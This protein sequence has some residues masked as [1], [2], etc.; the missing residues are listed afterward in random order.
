MAAIADTYLGERNSMGQVSGYRLVQ[1]IL[2]GLTLYLTGCAGVKVASVSTSDYMAARRGDI[3]TTGT[4]SPATG[5]VLQM[6]GIDESLC[7][8]ENARCRDSLVA[9]EALHSEQRLAALSELWLQ[10]AIDQ[11]KNKNTQLA[12]RIAAYIES[13]R[14]AYAYL[15]FTPRKPSQRALEDRQAQVR[16]YYN[17]ATQQAVTL[18]F[19][20]QDQA[21]IDIQEANGVFVIRLANWEIQG[22][23]AEVR[24]ASGEQVPNEVIP[25]AALTFKGIR[26]QYRRDGLGA[27]LVAVTAKRVV[28]KATADEVFSETPFPALTVMLD[29]SGENLEQVLKTQRVQML[30]FDP[31]KKEDLQLAGD[32]VPLAANFTSGYGLWLARSGFASQSL[33]TLF[34]R[35]EVLERPHVYLMQPY[36]PNRRIVIM[37]HGL[38]SSPE[39]WINVAN[40][41]LGDEQLRQ[42]Y[43]IWQVYYPTNAPIAY[44]NAT[45]AEALKTTLKHFDPTGTAIASNEVV[46]LGHS[47]G[48]VLSRLMVSSSGDLFW[49]AFTERFKM[50]SARQRKVREQLKPYAWFEPLPGVSR[51]IFVAAPHRGTPFAENRVAR[52]AANIIELPASMLARFGE[53]AQLLLDPSS[54]SGEALTRPLN[55]IA[56]LSDQDPFVR[57]AADLPIS[58]KVKYH[59]IMGN[60]TPK[61]SLDESS[62][63]VV[64]YKSA[65]LPGAVSEL[66]IPSWHSVQETPEAIVEIRRILHQHLAEISRAS[67]AATP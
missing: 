39:A 47:M 18:L 12:E 13:A 4:L 48:G 43:Q 65:H 20:H 54:A 27:E 52:W 28:T 10:T 17:Y 57:L 40:E 8:K 49:Q 62:D 21:D 15:F 46:L 19:K 5:S 38:A 58:P 31:Y 26:S 67:H 1:L 3:L 2:L 22:N 64:P 14:Y 37:L 29:F 61:V 11:E 51:A 59:S 16:D 33:L 41:V 45:I 23:L 35:G 34:G 36:D 63:G 24:L 30:G 60:D 53:V 56:N 6:V 25:A 44:N 50:S 9:T 66:I 7:S 55:S 42:N 32:Q